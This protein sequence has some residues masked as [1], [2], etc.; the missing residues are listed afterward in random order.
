MP[1]N[2]PSSNA[3]LVNQK[4]FLQFPSGMFVKW[5]HEQKQGH[6]IWFCGDFVEH[7]KLFPA[8]ENLLEQS[9][10]LELYL[11]NIILD[12]GNLHVI[13]SVMSVFACCF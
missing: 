13:L 10:D 11:R 3:V 4:Q 12:L 8:M 5:I 1:S 6:V 9:T 2:L 7:V